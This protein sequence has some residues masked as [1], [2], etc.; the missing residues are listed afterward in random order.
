VQLQLNYDAWLKWQEHSCWIASP[1][2]QQVEHKKDTLAVN[3]E[4]SGMQDEGAEST[5]SLCSRF[6]FDVLPAWSGEWSVLLFVWRS[7]HKVFV[8]CTFLQL[9][10]HMHLRYYACIHRALAFL[11]VVGWVALTATVFLFL[12]VKCSA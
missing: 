10:Q 3:P 9:G 12:L 4:L 2:P 6:L 1:F 11:L 7:K 8:R 5:S